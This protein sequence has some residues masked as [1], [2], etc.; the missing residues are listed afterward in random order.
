MRL[1]GL[2]CLF[3]IPAAAQHAHPPTTEKPVSLLEGMGAYTLPI[4]TRSPQAQSYFNQGL[5]LLYGFNRYE[6]LRSFK[7]AAELDPAAAMPYWGIAMAYGPHI[8]MD[9][10]GD[11]DAKQSCQAA[12]RGLK[13]ANAGSREHGWLTALAARCP[14]YDG[15]RYAVAMRDLHHRY[16]DDA[17]I[18]TC[19]A[20]ALMIPVRWKWWSADFKPAEGTEEAIRV[21]EAVLRRNSLHPGANHFYIHAVEASASPERAIASAQRLMGIVPAAGH[22]V[23][24]PGHIWVVLGEWNLAADVNE[25]AAKVDQEYMAKTGVTGSSYMGYWVHNL[26]FVAYARSMQGNYMKAREAAVAVQQAVT[27]MIDAMPSMVDAF[28]VWPIVTGVRFEQWE[29]VVAVAEPPDRLKTSAVVRH[30][31]RGLAHAKRGRRA[32]AEQSLESLRK[33]AGVLPADWM[34][35]NNKASDIARLAELSLEA[36]IN[37]SVELWRQAVELQDRLVYDEPPPW[38]YPIRESLAEALLRSGKAADAEAV[39]REGLRRSPN[40]VRMLRVLLA[41]VRAQNKTEAV[42]QLNQEIA[43]VGKVNSF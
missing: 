9:L 32:E 3:V 12:E 1:L 36:E 17:D 38:F 28:W 34:W 13:L 2:L 7:K 21:L 29:D 5:N 41:A 42:A 33:A 30:Y 15:A 20:E 24:M 16:P 11:S 18:A 14:Q 37:T 23:H 19:F 10:D 40:N 4:Q 22:L 6:S 25:R 26:H 8:N 31:A 43:R 39:G 27:P 35:L